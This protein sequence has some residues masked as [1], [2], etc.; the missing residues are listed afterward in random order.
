M[1][2]IIPR[3]H[4]MKTGL[5]QLTVCTRRYMAQRVWSRSK[6]SG[7]TE[8]EKNITVL[9]IEDKG[10]E[11]TVV[12]VV[13]PSYRMKEVQYYVAGNA[14]SFDRETGIVTAKEAGSAVICASDT[15][16][17][18]LTAL[19]VTVTDKSNMTAV[20]GNYSGLYHYKGI[21]WYL[22]NG[23][24]QKKYTGVV[25]NKNGWWYVEDGKVDFE[26]NSVE[27]NVNGWWYI[28]GGKVDFGYTGAVRHRNGWWRIENGK[29]NFDFNGIAENANGRWYIHN[30][31]VDFIFSG[32]ILWNN[33]KYVVKKRSCTEI[34]FLSELNL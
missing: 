25:Q 20:A 10:D 34:V 11:A 12:P 1:I 23:Y 2:Y 17:G 26:C 22:K 30:G 18:I 33:Q 19:K 3:L 14:V 15:Q 24:V 28:R 29:V 4:I 16:G 7:K 32:N 8:K 13:Y 6:Y 31:K 27:K 9:E 21:W 5:L